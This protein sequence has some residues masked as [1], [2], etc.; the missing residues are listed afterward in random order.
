MLKFK[1]V[2]FLCLFCL[3]GI[4]FADYPY[5]PY[6]GVIKYSGE[7]SSA[8]QYPWRLYSPTQSDEVTYKNRVYI[9]IAAATPGIPPDLAPS[10]WQAIGVVSNDLLQTIN[11]SMTQAPSSYA[12]KQAIAA[13]P[14]SSGGIASASIN[15]LTHQTI[16][17][18][19]AG[20]SYPQYTLTYAP[21]V[22]DDN[23][24]KYITQAGN[25]YFAWSTANPVCVTMKES[26]VVRVDSQAIL[27]GG[28]NGA[29]GIYGYSFA[30]AILING[31]SLLSPKIFNVV[32]NAASTYNIATDAG[33]GSPAFLVTTVKKED[34][35]CPAYGMVVVEQFVNGLYANYSMNID[36][37]GNK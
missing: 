1:N 33:S 27:A 30:S 36:Y 9:N 12:V 20:T 22:K 14:A 15:T 10:Q 26:G 18:Y 11:E 35:I 4:V 5:P 3:T 7:W 37:L 24:S 6:L 28:A 16:Y 8:Y 32:G 23:T 29:S 31:K 2:L 19:K 13:I 17:P 21:F 25:Q 34:Q